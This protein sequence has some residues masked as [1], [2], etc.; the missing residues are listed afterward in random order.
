MT[1]ALRRRRGPVAPADRARG[2]RAIPPRRAAAALAVGLGLLVALPGG[3]R[4]QDAAGTRPPER[5]AAGS[6]ADAARD[7]TT[8]ARPPTP[9][10]DA[11]RRSNPSGAPGGT[12]EPDPRRAPRGETAGT[13]EPDPR[14]APRGEAAGTS[15]PDPR[16]APR[17]ETAGT[18]EPTPRRAPRPGAAG[19]SG[20]DAAPATDAQGPGTAPPPGSTGAEDAP[21]PGAP[22]APDAAVPADG[23]LGAAGDA[24][25]SAARDAADA[26]VPDADAE[27]EA[28]AFAAD[29]G[30]PA[31]APDDAEGA[32]RAAPRAAADD[33]EEWATLLGE[34]LFERAERRAQQAEPRPPLPTEQREVAVRLV[35][36]DAA[37]GTLGLDLPERRVS[38]VGLVLLVLLA[39]VI[40]WLLDR[41]R[42]PLPDRGLFPRLLGL[43]HLAVRLATVVMVLMIVSRLLPGWLRPALLL[44]VAAVAIAL[45]FGAVWLVL[46]D[47]VGGLVLLTERRLQAGQWVVGD[48]FEGTVVQLGLRLT[49]LRAPDG[50]RLTVPNRHLVRSPVHA[51][52]RRFHEVEVELIVPSDAPAGRVRRAIEDAV[53]CSPHVPSEPALA[54]SRDP[55]RPD[56]WHLRVRLLDVAFAPAFEGQI[57]ER[58][59]DSLG[60]EP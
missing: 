20:P 28:E 15:E 50:T 47:V 39:L 48:G 24:G 27:A 57:L 59:E 38:T 43:T 26:G 49:T 18:N 4:A 53:L 14:R 30:V 10:R 58:V 60:R 31:E 55:A 37:A 17:G 33:E 16:R 22:T 7:E 44:S 3:A 19:T 42:R 45:G 35:G 51:S 56:R 52:A 25:P 6:E 12:S 36:C 34:L 11:A 2:R 46:P 1:R 41:L 9:G 32:E 21:P 40:L 54:L 8:G 13:S 5:R 23:G 29:G